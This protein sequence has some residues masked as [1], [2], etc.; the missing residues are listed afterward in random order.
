MAASDD[1]N[2]YLHAS[3]G[4]GGNKNISSGARRGHTERSKNGSAIADAD[5]ESEEDDYRWHQHPASDEQQ[6]K[7]R[8]TTAWIKHTSAKIILGS[9]SRDEEGHV[10]EL[11]LRGDAFENDRAHLYESRERRAPRVD[12]LDCDIE[13]A[14][15]LESPRKLDP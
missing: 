4:S 13:T 7:R 10:S 2:G 6:K 11:E 1:L 14:L 3:S 8:S 15:G 12:S 5:A 9:R